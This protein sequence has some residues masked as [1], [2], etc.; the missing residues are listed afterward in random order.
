[1]KSVTA[2]VLQTASACVMNKPEDHFCAINVFS[3]LEANK[4]L[5]LIDLYHGTRSML[6]LKLAPLRKI[7][8]NM[9]LSE[10]EIVVKSV[11][12][13]QR[14]VITAL[15]VPKIFSESVVANHNREIQFFAELT[16]SKPSTFR[17]Y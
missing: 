12:N 7:E 1:M 2:I 9:K 8:S 15:G 11:C 4:H 14:G 13:N 5:Y 10:Y 16:V 6:V 3:I 17:Q